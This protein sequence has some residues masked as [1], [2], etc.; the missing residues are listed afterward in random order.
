VVPE[1]EMIS[2]KLDADGMKAKDIEE[3]ERLREEEIAHC[4]SLGVSWDGVF[5]IPKRL[6]AKVPLCRW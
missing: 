4:R 3:I 5:V 1:R 6:A 2:E